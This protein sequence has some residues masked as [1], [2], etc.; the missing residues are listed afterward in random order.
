MPTELGIRAK[1]NLSN[2]PLSAN[3]DVRSLFP[4]NVAIYEE[5]G[6]AVVTVVDPLAMLGVVKDDQ[7]VCEVAEEAGARLKRVI[8]GLRQ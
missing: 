7:A 6:G 2:G 5:D 4:S 1:L 8:E 3:L